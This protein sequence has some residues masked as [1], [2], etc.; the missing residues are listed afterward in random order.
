MRTIALVCLVT[1]VAA[2]YARNTRYRR[3]ADLTEAASNHWE[4]GGGGEQ[5]GDS[6][7]EYGGHDEKGYKGFHGQEHGNKG[8]SDHEGL[9]IFSTKQI[10]IAST[11]ESFNSFRTYNMSNINLIHN[12]NSTKLRL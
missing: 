1:V 2:V 4:K 11:N 7:D 6:H 12:F 10:R 9:I 8:H 5:Y 3:D